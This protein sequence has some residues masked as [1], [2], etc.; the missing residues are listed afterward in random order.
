MWEFT[1]RIAI[2]RM[3]LVYLVWLIDQIL[4]GFHVNWI[5]GWEWK[6]LCPDQW[7]PA[8]PSHKSQSE[9]TKILLA[10]IYLSIFII[11]SIIQSEGKL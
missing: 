11:Y 4:N 8:Y 6:P 7:P 5:E 3:R 10:K 2:Y 1:G 9:T